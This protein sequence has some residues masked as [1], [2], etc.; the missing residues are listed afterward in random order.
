[1][2][3][4]FI[5]TGIR[6]VVFVGEQEY[7]ERVSAFS[8]DLPAN[9]LIFH[10]SGRATV[11]FNGQVLETEPN[12]VRF[13][14]AGKNTEYVVERHEEGAC[15]DICFYADRPIST[16]AFVMKCAKSEAIAALFKKAFSVWVAKGEG[17]Y[18]E[19]ISLLYKIF[20]ELQKQ[21]YLPETQYRAIKP[22]I[23][24]INEHFLEERI[25][26]TMLAERS[27]ISP[28]YLKKLFI[29]KFGMPPSKYIINLKINYACDLLQSG[30][31]RISQVAELC[32]YADLY[33][34]SRQFKDYMGISPSAFIENYKSSK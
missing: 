2:N 8:K 26:V 10:L 29:K 18:F 32:G 17:Y 9:E 33:F 7:T 28:S 25:S 1:M 20:A 22:A 23:D 21:S 16:E 14:P 5:I 13:L 31:Y 27:G 30:L 6:R 15:F 24:Y 11:R 12:T 4:D 19:C 34:F 3:R